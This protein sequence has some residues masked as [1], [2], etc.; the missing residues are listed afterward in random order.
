[1]DRIIIGIAYILTII[2]FGILI[3]I[4]IKNEEKSSTILYVLIILIVS[5]IIIWNIFRN[6]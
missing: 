6:I 3:K 1:M 2:F 4:R 5:L